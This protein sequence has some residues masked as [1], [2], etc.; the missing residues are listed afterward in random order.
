MPT[1]AVLF[2]LAALGGITMVGIRLSGQPR[3][4][5]WLALGHGAI[6]ASGLVTLIYTAAMQTI[7]LLAQIALGIF[8][9]AALGGA[10][11]FLGFHMKEKPLPI[12]L[13][14]GHGAAALTGFVLLVLA[15]FQ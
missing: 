9:L 4:P 3:P 13:M 2:L 12:P 11:I 10:T 14:L 15:I 7:P 5:T 8:V 6:A 1:A